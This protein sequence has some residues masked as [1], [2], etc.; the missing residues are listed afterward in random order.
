GLRLRRSSRAARFRIRGVTKEKKS[1][2]RTRA[3]HVSWRCERPALPASLSSMVSF[4]LLPHATSR[5]IALAFSIVAIGLGV[6]LYWL[7]P[8]QTSLVV[9]GSLGKD[10]V[11]EIVSVVSKERWQ[12]LRTAVAGREF[13]L[14]RRFLRARI[15]SVHGESGPNGQAV[16]A[17][18]AGFDPAIKV[19]FRLK[20]E[21]TNGWTH[22]R[23]FVVE[24]PPTQANQQ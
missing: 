24:N 15:E 22:E 18:R 5:R 11:S 12:L 13:T 8:L 7:V 2:E 23:W 21:G 19:L 20:H 1:M 16:V 17:C 3:G 9:T 10:D 14:L 4:V 6:G